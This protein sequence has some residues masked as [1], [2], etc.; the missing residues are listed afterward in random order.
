[1]NERK[2]P[3]WFVPLEI[4][5]DKELTGNQKLVMAVVR[6]LTEL[7]M[8]G[9]RCSNRYIAEQTGMSIDAVRQ[10]LVR[11]RKKGALSPNETVFGQDFKGARLKIPPVPNRS[12]PCQIVAGGVPNRSAHVPF[13]DTDTINTI[14]QREREPNLLLSNKPAILQAAIRDSSFTEDQASSAFDKLYR[15]R[16]LSGTLGDVQNW[17]VLLKAALTAGARSATPAPASR[18]TPKV[19]P[20]Q[21]SQFSRSH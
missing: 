15:E 17:P 18:W 16:E 6:N 3:G 12:A 8:G 11:L 5:Q 13:Q 4:M 21:A 2:E 1:M 7:D 20:V 9:C 19:A 10:I 14:I